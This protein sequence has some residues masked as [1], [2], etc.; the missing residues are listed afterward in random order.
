MV[1]HFRLNIAVDDRAEVRY[2]RDSLS[3]T[4]YTYKNNP[5]SILTRNSCHYREEES[6]IS[7]LTCGRFFMVTALTIFASNS[8]SPPD[9]ELKR[10]FLT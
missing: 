10:L 8:L 4:I 6:G 9:M 7:S 1:D 2:G 5:P 3:Q